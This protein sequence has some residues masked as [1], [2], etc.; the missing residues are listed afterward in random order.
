LPLPALGWEPLK[1]RD[2]VVTSQ[3]DSN[4]V[5]SAMC[6]RGREYPELSLDDNILRGDA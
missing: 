5:L 2:I 4:H 3:I 6:F 1:D